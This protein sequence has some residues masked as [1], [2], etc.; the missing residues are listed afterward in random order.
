MAIW[1]GT[2]NEKVTLFIN[3]ILLLI[4]NTEIQYVIALLLEQIHP[5]LNI[6]QRDNNHESSQS[7]VLCRQV[8]QM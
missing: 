5:F 4:M 1:I 8:M 7:K 2:G 3:I 6:I